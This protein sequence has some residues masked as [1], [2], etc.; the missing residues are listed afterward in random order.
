[1]Y[2]NVYSKF[3][4]EG[5]SNEVGSVH[6]PGNYYDCAASAAWSDLNNLFIKVQIIDKYFGTLDINVG[7]RDEFI[8]IHMAKC[9]EDFLDEYVGF[10][11]GRMI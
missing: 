11:G 9:A 2:H 8:G 10:A 7:F 5:Y 4:Q 6:A 1:M 3:P